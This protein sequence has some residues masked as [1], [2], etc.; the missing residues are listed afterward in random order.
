MLENKLCQENSSKPE[1]PGQPIQ[2]R[3]PLQ[4][5]AHENLPQPISQNMVNPQ[6]VKCYS[7]EIFS[8]LASNEENC[9]ANVDYFTLHTE[10]NHTSR[11]FLID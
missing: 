7:Q 3:P 9:Q 1:K 6:L 2:S 5:L 8:F 10:I 11:A 4:N